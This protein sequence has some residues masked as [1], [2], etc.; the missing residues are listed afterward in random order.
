MADFLNT[1]I[2]HW[3]PSKAIWI[4]G[5]TLHWDARCSGIYIGFGIGIVCHL[6]ANRK[7]N[8]LPQW[9]VL[10]VN[11]LLFLPLF[12]DVITIKYGLR[13]PSNDIRYLTGLF[14]GMA[15]SVY[16][17][18]AF[19]VHVLRG[20]HESA[21]MSPSRFTALFMLVVAAFSLRFWDSVIA[22]FTLETLSFW[23]FIGLF[24][25]LAFGLGK[26][27]SGLMGTAGLRRGSRGRAELTD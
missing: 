12:I 20:T 17:Y 2:F 19:M 5:H 27:L 26:V 24:V 8:A 13:G 15:F 3:L 22:Y 9:P 1:Y 18:P 14:F 10:I 6:I 25:M 7:T 23:G 21:G 4:S 16:L 11:T